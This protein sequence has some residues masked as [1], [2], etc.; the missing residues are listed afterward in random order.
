MP[1]PTP[2]LLSCQ[3]AFRGCSPSSYVSL[4]PTGCHPAA[5]SGISGEAGEQSV[6]E[7]ALPELLHSLSSG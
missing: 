2:R 7:A 4:H 5:S 3:L 6:L 1:A